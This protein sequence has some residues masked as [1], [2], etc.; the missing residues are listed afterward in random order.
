M[1]D[2]YS[3]LEYV[4]S[5]LHDPTLQ[6][7]GIVAYLTIEEASSFRLISRD[8]LRTIAL[9]PWG[10]Q[11][12]VPGS[13]LKWKQVRLCAPLLPSRTAATHTRP[14]RTFRNA[15]RARLWATFQ[16]AR[17]SSTRALTACA[18]GG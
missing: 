16:T 11:T 4:L 18:A 10:S 7:V 12:R 6:G 9:G 2:A 15:S 8:C 13:I 5:V 3:N 17:T 14:T 1:V